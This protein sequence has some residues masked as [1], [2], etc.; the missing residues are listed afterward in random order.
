MT[1]TAIKPVQETQEGNGRKAAEYECYTAG[2]AL[3]VLRKAR[4]FYAH[5]RHDGGIKDDPE[6]YRPGYWR[7]CMEVSRKVAERHV[8]DLF[9][10][11]PEG[12]GVFLRI[13]VLSSW[14][15][16]RYNYDTGKPGRGRWH[17]SAFI[18]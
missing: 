8:K 10:Y 12:K 14:H 9:Q 17:V 4:T 18:G 7:G 11:E 13:R 2:D 16:G 15:E 5:T 3:A 1:A 6:H